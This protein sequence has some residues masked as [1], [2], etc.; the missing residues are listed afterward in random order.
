MEEKAMKIIKKLLNISSKLY[1]SFMEL[2]QLEDSKLKEYYIF[3]DKKEEIKR[4]KEEEHG[5]LT[6]LE[7]YI[8][9]LPNI[10]LE[11]TK[12]YD[13][14]SNKIFLDVQDNYIR[15]SVLNHTITRLKD[16][17]QQ[18]IVK[19]QFFAFSINEI[20]KDDTYSGVLSLLEQILKTIKDPEVKRHLEE[21]KYLIFFQREKLN[22]TFKDKDYNIDE[23]YYV[24]SKLYAEMIHL[25]PEEY[26]EQLTEINKCIVESQILLMLE[27]TDNDLQK[28]QIIAN[29]IIRK[30][31]IISACLSL[32]ENTKNEIDEKFKKTQYYKN[33]KQYL[34]IK[35]LLE[36][37]GKYQEH[38]LVL[39]CKGNN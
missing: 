11:L 33:V 12:Q 17:Y 20:I 19:N 26:N 32:N 3:Q 10:I 24:T 8:P 7:D 5:L 25:N 28:P 1:Q 31:F 6:E 30:C 35:E 22:E 39:S 16:Y 38:R 2:S 18:A 13:I 27:T 4:I 14:K 37:Q 34:E 15:N 29:Q 23:N 36:N 21:T 9:I